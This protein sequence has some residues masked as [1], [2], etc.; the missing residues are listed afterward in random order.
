VCRVAPLVALGANP[1]L[2]VPALVAGMVAGADSTNDMDLLRRGGMGR[3]FSGVRARSTLGIFLRAFTF[4]NVRQLDA[5]DSRFLP[6][7][8]GQA[9]ILAGAER[10]VW[11]DVD[12]TVIQIYGY[13]KQAA[14]RGYTG[15]KGLNALVATAST[16]MSGAGDR[17][18]AATSGE[19]PLVRGAATSVTEALQVARRCGACGLVILPADSAFYTRAVITAAHEAGAGFSVTAPL[20]PS[21]TRAV[22][23]IAD[24]AWTP[25]RYPAGDLRRSRA[26][27]DLFTDSVLPMLQ[28]EAHDRRHAVIEKVFADL[29]AGRSRTCRRAVSRP[30][31]PRWCWPPSLS[32]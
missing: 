1:G 23:A 3:L 29:K 32:T 11:L 22:A 19:C 5:V 2:K 20:Y 14:G 6:R 8:A 12:D 27:L 18:N 17:R 10:M 16:P 9:P 28:A 21:M 13:A 30:T 4:G 15:V 26:T 7:P 24:N 25:I 31:A